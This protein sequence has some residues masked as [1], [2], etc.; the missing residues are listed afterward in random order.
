MFYYCVFLAVVMLFATIYSKNPKNKVA[1][2]A[3]LAIMILFAGLRS[4]E[5]GTDAAGYA[6]EFENGRRDL[7]GGLLEKINEEPAFFYLNKYL[8]MISNQCWCLFTGIALLT[9]S[10]VLIAVKRQTDKITIP[11]FVFITL[12]LYTFVFN[13]ARQGIA[14]SVYMLSFKYLFEKGKKAFLKY[15]LF[16]FLAAMFHKT[17]VIALPLYYLFR[18]KYSTKMLVLIAIMGMVMGVLMPKFLAFAG[19]QEDRYM[20][21]STVASGGKLLTVFYILI[22][23]YFIFQRNKVNREYQSK[24]DVFLNMMCFGTLIYIVVQFSGVYVEMTRF[25]AYF[26]V[27]AIFLWDY[28]YA[29]DCKPKL[30]YSFAIIIGHL[31]Y[32]FIFCNRMASLTPYLFN[33]N[34]F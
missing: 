1:L 19:T 4:V 5:V 15:C 21:Y 13:A 26:Q 28:I 29:S 2:F 10:C 25:A 23:S 12:G 3:T 32:Y 7:E 34:I 14:V 24:Y 6:R 31:I 20:L 16:V 33:P 27:A 9:Y 17:V 11:L 22:T 30:L 18:M 8:G